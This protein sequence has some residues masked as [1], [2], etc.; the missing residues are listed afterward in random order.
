LV[1]TFVAFVF[2]L[3]GLAGAAYYG[4]HAITGTVPWNLPL[5]RLRGGEPMS[6]S[7]SASTALLF[8]FVGLVTLAGVI[9]PALV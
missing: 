6:R 2:G 8:A 4:S 9:A 7:Y 1:F 3:A 5:P